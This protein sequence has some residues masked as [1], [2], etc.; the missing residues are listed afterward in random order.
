MDVTKRKELLYRNVWSIQ[1]VQDY[2]NITPN[3]W[4]KVRKFIKERPP[5]SSSVYRDDVFSILKT[6]VD[7]EWEVIKKLES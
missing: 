7:K 4:S 1:E 5:F 2:F 3:K 6:S